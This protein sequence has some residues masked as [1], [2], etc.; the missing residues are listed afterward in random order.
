L[1]PGTFDSYLFGSLI[2]TCSIREHAFGSRTIVNLILR[3]LE[4][5]EFCL[6]LSIENYC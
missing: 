3:C 1:I 6:M 4:F 5:E 2:A